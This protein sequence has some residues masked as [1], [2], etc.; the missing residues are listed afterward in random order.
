MIRAGNLEYMFQPGI[1]LLVVVR[2]SRYWFQLVIRASS[3]VSSRDRQQRNLYNQRIK[4]SMYGS[5]TK[6]F[7]LQ[8][9]VSPIIH[10]TLHRVKKRVLNFLAFNQE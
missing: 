7:N 8:R 1:I 10:I 6:I 4:S 5:P 3:V 9:G 2:V